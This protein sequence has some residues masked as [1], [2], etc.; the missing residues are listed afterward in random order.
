MRLG[1]DVLHMEN[2]GTLQ[3]RLLEERRS[4]EH[5]C[6]VQILFR[7]LRLWGRM[8]RDRTAESK[9]RFDVIQI[10]ARSAPACYRPMSAR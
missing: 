7:S 4:S 10:T 6:R 2:A 9:E 3:I 8:L 1:I 5:R